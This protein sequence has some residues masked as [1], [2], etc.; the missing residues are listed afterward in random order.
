M[1][2]LNAMLL[3]GPTGVGKTPLGRFLE[4][5]KFR[6]RKCVHFDFGENLRDIAAST[7]PDEYLSK[8]DVETVACA[9][10]SGALLENEDFHIV[11]SILSL[12]KLL[13]TVEKQFCK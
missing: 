2:S 4:Q 10:N 12:R 11:K 8:K 9:I 3:I 13:K 5:N 1:S 7:V 6:G